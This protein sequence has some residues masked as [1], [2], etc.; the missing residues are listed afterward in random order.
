MEY[1]VWSM[2]YGVWSMEYGVWSM[3]YGVWSMAAHVRPSCFFDPETN[4]VSFIYRI[5]NHV[6]SLVKKSA[7]QKE[8]SPAMERLGE[9]AALGSWG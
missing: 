9:T 5:R 3:E 8:F 2:E 1:G 4:L 7:F 6:N